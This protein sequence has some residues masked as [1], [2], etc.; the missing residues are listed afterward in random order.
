MSDLHLSH[1]PPLVRAG[2]KNWYEVMLRPLKQL[3]DL[4]HKY[5]VPVIVA[6]DIFDDGWRPHRCPPELIG[7]AIN[8]L[9]ALRTSS[10]WSVFAVPGQHDLPYHRYQDIHK[11]AYMVLAQAGVLWSLKETHPTEIITTGGRILHLHGF[12]WGFE[13]KPLEKPNPLC[14]EIAVV[15]RYVWSSEDNAYPGVNMDQHGGPLRKRLHNYDVIV[16]G[17][18]HIPFYMPKKKDLPALWNCGTFM[19]RRLNERD[20]CPSVGL[21][22][23]DLTITRHTL[24]TSKDV[25]DDTPRA[26]NLQR[27]INPDE[28]IK[29]LQDLGNEPLSFADVLERIRKARQLPDEVW[30]VILKALDNTHE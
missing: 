18:N 30:E 3:W 25:F 1:R 10:Q 8:A 21:L 22:H 27:A 7:F 14:I 16:T 19:R 15:H 13:P 26:E 11:S 5:Q 6:G 28:L 29:E 20:L 24:D 4:Q 9:G 23:A 12:P 17:D 2:E